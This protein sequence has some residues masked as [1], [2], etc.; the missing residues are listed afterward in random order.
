MLTFFLIQDMSHWNREGDTGWCI[1]SL[2]LLSGIISVG[3]LLPGGLQ[4]AT[5]IWS[6][7][8][9]YHIALHWPAQDA[10][11]LTQITRMEILQD[12]LSIMQANIWLTLHRHK[13]RH[14][15]GEGK[16]SNRTG[17]GCKMMVCVI[18]LISEV[19]WNFKTYPT[20]IKNCSLL[21][22]RSNV[23]WSCKFVYNESNQIKLQ[24]SY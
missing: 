12:S 19:K 4:T 7:G 3:C 23:R 16:L 14:V 21:L 5:W 6:T 8:E 22:I 2:S 1:I 20:L 18:K 17:W 24:N 15:F 11:K 13:N 10:C 9:Q